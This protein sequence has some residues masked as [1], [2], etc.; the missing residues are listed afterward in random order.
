MQ[1]DSSYQKDMSSIQDWA[2]RIVLNLQKDM[3]F[4][5]HTNAFINAV[6]WAEYWLLSLLLFE[7]LLLGFTI[8]TQQ[9]WAVQ[10][11]L[12][13]VTF[14][15]VSC[16]QYINEWCFNNW[17]TFSNQN[18]FDRSGLFITV[19]LSLP[20]CLISLIALILGLYNASQL[21]I[22]VKTH[23]FKQH[24]RNKHKRLQKEKQKKPKKE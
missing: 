4:W 16:A 9:N 2:R 12:F 10:S 22:K 24:Y 21:V 13:I 17:E 6:D 11:V 14:I 8:Y 23:E 20:L 15:I 3:T 18:Y 5:D 1:P 7:L 19:I